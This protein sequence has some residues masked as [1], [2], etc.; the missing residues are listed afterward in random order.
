M[1]LLGEGVEQDGLAQ[2]HERRAAHALRQAEHH[3]AFEIPGEAAQRRG[4]HEADDGEEQEAAPPEPGG[5]IAGERHHHG[6][7]DEIRGEHPGDLIGRGAEG[8]EHVRDRHAHDGDVEHFEDAVSTTATTRAT[9]G[10]Y[11]LCG[12]SGGAASAR[13]GSAA[14]GFA[15]CGPGRRLAASRGLAFA[16]AHF[17]SLVVSIVTVVLAPTRSGL[18]AGGLVRADAHREALRHLDPVAGGV[19]RRQHREGGARARA[20]AFDD[21]VEGRRRDTCRDGS[22]PAGRA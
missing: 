8:A 16:P 10:L 18:S 11:S 6:G 15:A 17:S 12:G 14:G 9:D 5:E 7:G 22:S 20:D 3:H 13:G 1:L 19:L 4:D 21:A 2:R